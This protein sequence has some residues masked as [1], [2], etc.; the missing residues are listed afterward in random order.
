M[1]G[2]SDSYKTPDESGR[3]EGRNESIHGEFLV[4]W[5]KWLL[6]EWV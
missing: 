2:F 4:A 5:K 6:G 3:V 1:Q